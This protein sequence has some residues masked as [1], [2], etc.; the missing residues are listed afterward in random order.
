MQNTIGDESAPKIERKHKKPWMTDEI[1]TLMDERKLAKNR[2]QKEYS[3][4]HNKIK[5]KM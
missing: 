3:K 1:L 2:N 5:K 4:L